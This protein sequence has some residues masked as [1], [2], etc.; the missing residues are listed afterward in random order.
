MDVGRGE[1]QRDEADSREVGPE[2]LRN[3][4]QRAKREG[5]KEVSD[6]HRQLYWQC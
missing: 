5:M 1:E 3:Q 4:R 2:R 6:Q